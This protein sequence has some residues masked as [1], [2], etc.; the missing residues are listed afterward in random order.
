[1]TRNEGMKPPPRWLALILA[2]GLASL[3]AAEPNTLT[4]AEKATG[5]RLLF[6][7]HSLAGW[8]GFRTDTPGEAWR[9]TDGVLINGGKTGDLMTTS[10]HGDFEFTFDWKISVGGN[11]GVIYRIALG[12][13]ATYRTGPEY[14]ILDNEKAA[15][16]KLANHLAGSLYDVGAAPTRDVTKPVGEWNTG[17]I[18]VRGW[19]VE[20]WLNGEKLL[21][22]DLASEV[23]RGAIAKSKFKDWP[24]FASMARG[25][26]AL[27]DHNDPVSF[28]NLKIRGL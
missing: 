24:K 16:N 9:V 15:D 28:R 21:E 25:F 17:R 14:Q 13:A 5:W 20:H 2:L 7:G 4:E 22:V 3:S 12:E 6:D 26:I 19:R 11:S 8:R 10:V 23:G 18:V 1:M 27:Q